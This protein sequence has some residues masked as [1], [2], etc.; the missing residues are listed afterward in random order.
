MSFISD[1]KICVELIKRYYDG[2]DVLILELS[3]LPNG[4]WGVQLFRDILSIELR[5]EYRYVM[6][7]TV[8]KVVFFKEDNRMTSKF[9]VEIPYACRND[10]IDVVKQ[11]NMLVDKNG[12]VMMFISNLPYSLS[13]FLVIETNTNADEIDKIIKMSMLTKISNRGLSE[14]TLELAERKWDAVALTNDM[15]IDMAF[16]Y[17]FHFTEKAVLEQKGYSF[18]SP[19]LRKEIF[20]SYCHKDK[21][22][23]LKMVD[24]MKQSG[25]NVWVDVI[26]IDLGDSI[27]ENVD[28]KLRS[29]DMSIIFISK[30]TSTAMFARHE[31]RTLF[32]Q[33]IN[34]KKPLIIVK[35][36][37][38]KPS[39]IFIG[40]GDIL[41]FD[42][43]E[44]PDVELLIEQIQKKL[45]KMK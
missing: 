16:K 10:Y 33:Y 15:A 3:E 19:L 11:I 22:F 37:E 45:A 24:A 39:D 23:I 31:L 7:Y 26:E 13:S 27:I 18:T 9:T 41:Y 14:F 21:A 29:C 30:H 25:L 43:S 17:G 34:T 35:L 5:V 6:C 8:E 38:T 20:V 42:Y 44:I 40:L 2:Q 4:R 28:A 36:D 1:E 32:S 12:V